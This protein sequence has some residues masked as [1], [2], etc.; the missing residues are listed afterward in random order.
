ML[1]D[2]LNRLSGQWQVNLETRVARTE[3]YEKRIASS[4]PS[5]GF[6]VLLISSEILSN[7]Y[8]RK[9]TQERA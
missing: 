7:H 4:R 6:F 5:L 9:E 2:A 8:S 1:L 3:L